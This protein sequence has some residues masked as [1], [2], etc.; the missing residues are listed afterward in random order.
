VDLSAG[1]LSLKLDFNQV[2]AEFDEIHAPE[3]CADLDSSEFSDAELQRVALT[4]LFSIVSMVF[5]MSVALM[6]KYNPQLMAHPNKLIYYM[7]LC[8]GIIAW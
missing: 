2:Q 4:C 1:I 7:C 8:E 5:T 6:M 3:T